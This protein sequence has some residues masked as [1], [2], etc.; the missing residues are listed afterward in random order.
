MISGT[1]CDG[2][3]N[4]LPDCSVCCVP[5]PKGSCI[6]GG[7]FYDPGTEFNEHCMKFKCDNGKWKTT[8]KYNGECGKCM[9]NNDPHFTTFDKEKFDW[10][11]HDT[12]IISQEGCED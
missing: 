9:F 2:I 3:V 7:Q 8:N 4:I 12:Y 1:R 5:V 10:H 11:G 6:I